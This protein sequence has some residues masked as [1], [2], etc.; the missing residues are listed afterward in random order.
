MSNL[1]I[2]NNDNG[3]VVIEEW[4][5]QDDILVFAGAGTVVEGTILARSTVDSKMYV[6]DTAGI[7]GLNIPKAV[8]TYD[9]VATGAGDV[10]IRQLIAGKVKKERLVIDAD[11]DDSNITKAILDELRDFVV[12]PQNVQDLSVLDFQ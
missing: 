9:V 3:S 7:N 12:V 2:T 10:P 6:Y 8:I 1:T 4:G 11:G 5:W